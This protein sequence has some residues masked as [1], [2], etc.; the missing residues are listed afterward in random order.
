VRLGVRCCGRI[1]RGVVRSDHVVVARSELLCNDALKRE[2]AGIVGLCLAG[3]DHGALG[4][5]GLKRHGRV[6][7]VPLTADRVLLADE[8][9]ARLDRDRRVDRSRATVTLGDSQRSLSRL[10]RLVIRGDH[11]VVTRLSTLRNR[12]VNREPT[13]AVSLRR[14]R[15]TNR[16]TSRVHQLNTRRR[17]RRE[18]LTST[19]GRLTRSNLRRVN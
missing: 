18:A 10:T 2:G 3:V 7:G 6:R 14:T 8:D 19:R 17:I 15:L 12:K 9:L 16:L 5:Y 13:I 4:V 1:T 11:G